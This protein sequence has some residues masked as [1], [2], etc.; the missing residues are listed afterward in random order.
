[1]FDVEHNLK[2]AAHRRD[3]L[4]KEYDI[5]ARR[6][7]FNTS[8]VWTWATLL[9]SVNGAALG[10]GFRG[11]TG[12]SPLGD[13]LSFTFVGLAGSLALWWWQAA[14]SRWHETI[15]VLYERMK[16]IEFECDMWSN[17]YIDIHDETSFNGT[18]LQV[19]LRKATGRAYRADPNRGT[20]PSAM[21]SHLSLGV[22]GVW[23]VVVVMKAFAVPAKGH[24]CATWMQDSC[25]AFDSAD[26][27][28]VALLSAVAVVVL[29]GPGLWVQRRFGAARPAQ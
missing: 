26:W 29:V 10:I 15:R 24:L 28:H 17:R 25:I 13:Y 9:V 14:S 2:V 22:P 27:A 6:A 21:R 19:R 11:A 20:S 1:M 16:E 4:L 23:T 12:V 18:A 8:L 7:D 5:C 3:T